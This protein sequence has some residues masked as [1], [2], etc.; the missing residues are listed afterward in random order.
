MARF[1]LEDSLSLCTGLLGAIQSTLKHLLDVLTV[2]SCD[3]ATNTHLMP[4]HI[5]RDGLG[6]KRKF[7][8][9]PNNGNN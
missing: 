5:R 7:G 3:R 4:G 6:A 1:D 9:S 8:C 2:L